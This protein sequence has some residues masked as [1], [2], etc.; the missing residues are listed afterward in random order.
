MHSPDLGSTAYSISN[1]RGPNYRMRCSIGL[2]LCAGRRAL[3]PSWHC[4]PSEGV[5]SHG[6]CLIVPA[7]NASWP[8][9]MRVP[10]YAKRN[11]QKAQRGKGPSEYNN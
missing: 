4:V 1:A 3:C 2:G 10:G 8:I 6:I 9:P 7:A 5:V 11:A